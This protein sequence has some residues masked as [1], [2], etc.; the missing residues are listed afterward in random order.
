MPEPVRIA[1]DLAAVLEEAREALSR[2]APD[3]VVRKMLDEHAMDLRADR[4]RAYRTRVTDEDFRR[5]VRDEVDTKAAEITRR[6]LE[7]AARNARA[8]VLWL[9]GSVG[10]GKTVAALWALSQRDGL[11]VSADELR[12]AYGQEHDEARGLRAR[13]EA[14]ALL[15]VDDVGTA[16]A[17]DGEEGRALYEAIN[18]RLGGRRQTIVTGNLDA[19]EIR[20]RYDERLLSRVRHVGAIFDCGAKSLRRGAA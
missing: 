1:D 13:I 8:R 18:A 16:R 14:T 15:V 10:V 3:D 5:I 11:L 9:A 6:F 12:R 17:R 20:G 4:I 2:V 7:A 19:A